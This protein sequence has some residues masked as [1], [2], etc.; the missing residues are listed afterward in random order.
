MLEMKIQLAILVPLFHM[1]LTTDETPELD[2]GINL[3]SKGSILLRP[4]LRTRAC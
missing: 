3:R 1:R 4:E 2:L